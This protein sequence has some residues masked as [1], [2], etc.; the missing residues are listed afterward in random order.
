MTAA[1]DR[2]TRPSGDFEA[3]HCRCRPGCLDVT[4][5]HADPYVHI[6]AE[7]LELIRAGNAAPWAQ[8]NGDILTINATNR[9]VIYRIGGLILNGPVA[10]LAYEAEWPD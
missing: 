4:I 5:V 1:I 8:L 3:K 2:W 7:L 9:T 10:G 6:S